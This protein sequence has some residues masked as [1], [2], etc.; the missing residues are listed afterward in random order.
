MLCPYLSSIFPRISTISERNI[1]RISATYP[2]V[3]PR[4]E[5]ELGTTFTEKCR[6]LP[7]TFTGICA[8]CVRI[9]RCLSP[10]YPAICARNGRDVEPSLEASAAAW[11][12][13]HSRKD[14]GVMDWANNAAWET[15][16][17]EQKRRELYDRQVAL[18]DT[19]LEHRAISQEQHDKSLQDLTVKMGY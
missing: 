18:L 6:V 4:I 19:F 16:T 5:P 1:Q 14:G 7:A 17:P 8:V 9:V 11:Y 2:A 15:L 13:S 3:F 10:E 12:N